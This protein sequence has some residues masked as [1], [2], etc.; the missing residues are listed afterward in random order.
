MPTSDAVLN[1][2][3]LFT[4]A[5]LFCGLLSMTTTAQA[6][7]IDVWFGTTTPKNGLSKGIYY[8]KFD[9]DKGS[10]SNPELAAE[11][12]SPGFL[13]MHPSGKMLY[14]VGRLKGEAAVV[15]Y[16]IE[17]ADGKSTLTLAN[18]AAIGDGGAAHVSVDRT[19]KVLLTAQYGGG[20]T[21][22]FDLDD[23]GSIKSRR[24]LIKHEGGSGV[25]KGRQDKPHAHW[26]G[27]SPDNQFAFRSR[28]G[29]GQ[30]CDLET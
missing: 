22:L 17:Q 8:A 7:Q 29:N 30:S 27:T 19:G 6:E 13:A 5:I 18:S 10:L 12:T 26:T 28:L 15:A 21:A 4:A 11:I 20:S 23:D 25:V 14:A 16:R 1:F 2:H 9:T 3:R 24:Q